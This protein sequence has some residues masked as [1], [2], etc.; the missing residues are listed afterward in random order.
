[1]PLQLAK[2]KVP[3]NWTQKDELEERLLNR[4]LVL[5]SGPRDAIGMLVGEAPGKEEAMRGEPFI[6][7]SGKM[8]TECCHNAGLPRT[9]WY[10]TNVAKH[11]PYRN[12]FSVFYE[13]KKQLIPTKALEYLWEVLAWEIEQVNPNIIVALGRHALYALC[14]LPGIEKY[15]GSILPCKLVPGYKVV[16]AFHPRAIQQ[17]YY[18][19]PLLELDLK[20]AKRESLYR[21]IRLPQRK[22]IVPKNLETIKGF[23]DQIKQKGECTVDIETDRSKHL[24]D[25][26]GFGIDH[27]TALVIP[28]FYLGRD[29]EDLLE[30]WS[31]KDEVNYWTVNEEMVIWQ[32]ITEILVDPRIKKIAHNGIFDFT[33]LARERGII[34]R[35]FS[36]DTMVAHHN[37]YTEMPKGL[38]FCVSIYTDEPYFKD[39]KKKPEPTEEYHQ[40][41]WAYNGK[42]CMTTYEC[43]TELVTE[44]KSLGVEKGFQFDMKML[45]PIIYMQLQGLRVDTKLRSELIQKYQNE[46]GFDIPIT[47]TKKKHI[48]GWR[49]K[50][51]WEKIGKELNVLSPKQMQEFLY[52]DLGLKV[53][54]KR[55][56][57]NP[58][59]DEK[60]IMQLYYQTKNPILKEIIELR[61]GKDFLSDVLK[62]PLDPHTGRLHCSFNWTE[63]FRFSSSKSAYDVGRN[64]LNIPKNEARKMIIP[65]PGME[66]GEVD[67]ERAEAHIVAFLI[68]DELILDLIAKGG[69][70]HKHRASMMYGKSIDEVTKDERNNAKKGVHAVHYDVGMNTFLDILNEGRDVPF[71][72]R[73]GRYIF[74]L[75][76][77]KIP[78]ARRYQEHI[79]NLLKKDRTLWSLT[80]RRRTFYDRFYVWNPTWKIWQINKDLLREAYAWIPQTTVPDVTNQ[81]L[82]KVYYN[83]KKYVNIL[84]QIHDALLFEY[85]PEH[86][87]IAHEIVH[88]AMSIPLYYQGRTMTMGIEHKYGDNWLE[89][90]VYKL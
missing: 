72:P 73:E 43:K 23:F 41:R 33:Y 67:L 16:P 2:T 84:L 60:A 38:D 70:I 66:L 54:H 57:G 36:F 49:E 29:V 45:E 62:A 4:V 8:L 25:C 50:Q 51:F 18:L 79:A 58:T 5:P 80:G 48:P 30:P 32:W 20:K 14:Y 13:D 37:C 68:N 74:N 27:K 10:I 7:P 35:N 88:E 46:F 56:T 77:E 65:N 86:R 28:F 3:K 39:E 64:L 31:K 22:T 11:K 40:K 90:E 69:D 17:R 89:M 19:K 55:S 21:D 42:D 15:R 85:K 44:M 87:R 26:I 63:T 52:E 53:I 76:H 78:T 9:S 61:K 71:T 34:V 6:G 1:L 81:A 75:I 59:A 82:S 24:I 47:T 83:Y 12:D